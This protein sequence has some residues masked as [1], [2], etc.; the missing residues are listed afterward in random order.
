MNLMIICIADGLLDPLFQ[1]RGLNTSMYCAGT[2]SVEDQR[3]RKSKK[4]M[5]RRACPRERGEAADPS[6]DSSL[7][8]L[9]GRSAHDC[10]I[11]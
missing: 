8:D 5:T 4:G 3:R 6:R 10:Q 11:K 7:N 2:R 9:G 1:S